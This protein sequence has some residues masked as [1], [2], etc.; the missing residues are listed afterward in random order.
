MHPQLS[1]WL[2]LPPPMVEHRT[3]HMVS[4]C[5]DV[6][7]SV[8]PF[9]PIGSYKVGHLVSQGPGMALERELSI[10]GRCEVAWTLLHTRQGPLYCTDLG[11]S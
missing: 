4:I 5:H 2:V 1:S 10:L 11:S 3:P 8:Y 7:F 9:H 6:L